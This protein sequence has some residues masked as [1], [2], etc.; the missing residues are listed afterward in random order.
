VGGSVGCTPFGVDDGPF[1]VAVGWTGASVIGTGVGR[2]EGETV[3]VPVG[4]CA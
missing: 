3:G 2:F 4:L 1:V